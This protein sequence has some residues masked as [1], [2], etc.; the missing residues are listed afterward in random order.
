MPTADIVATFIVTSHLQRYGRGPA[1]ALGLGARGCR[2]AGRRAARDARVTPRA[3]CDT[4]VL[5]AGFCG[6]PCLLQG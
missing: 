3:L 6:Y 5:S 1:E 4:N 2:G